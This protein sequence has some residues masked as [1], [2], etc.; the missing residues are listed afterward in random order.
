MSPWLNRPLENMY[1]AVFIDAIMVKVRDGQVGNRPFYIAVGVDLHGHRDILGIWAGD[2]DGESAKYWYA[3][4]AD[5][6]N[7][8]ECKISSFVDL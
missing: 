2:G 6:K 3:V 7:T 8:G 5:L 1:A 4:L